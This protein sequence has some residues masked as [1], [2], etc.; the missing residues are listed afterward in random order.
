MKGKTSPMIRSKLIRL[1][2]PKTKG[3]SP[4]ERSSISSSPVTSSSTIKQ[5][6]LCT[7]SNQLQ[8]PATPSRQHRS[9]SVDVSLSALQFDDAK[10]TIDMKNNEIIITPT[11]SKSIVDEEIK[12]TVHFNEKIKIS[13]KIGQAFDNLQDSLQMLT[14]LG[15]NSIEDK[16]NVKTD[17]LNAK[18]TIRGPGSYIR[19]LI[20]QFSEG[21]FESEDAKPESERALPTQSLKDKADAICKKCLHYKGKIS[22]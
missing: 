17:E 10:I 4:G 16:N 22:K 12:K 1:L 15:N 11:G 3:S 5:D 8:V 6:L 18:L 19:K 2:M 7:D 20:Q 13:D 9:K 14:E 21:P